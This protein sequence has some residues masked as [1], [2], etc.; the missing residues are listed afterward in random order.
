MAFENIS[1]LVKE[2]EFKVFKDIAATEKGAVIAACLPKGAELS[3]KDIDNLTEYVKAEGGSGLA[4]FRVVEGKLDSPIAKFFPETLQK[5]LIEKL[6]ANA[7]D[8]ILCVADERPKALKLLGLVRLQ[9]G[10]TRGLIDTKQFHFSWVTDFPLFQFDAEENRWVSEHHPF[11]SPNMEDWS[12]HKA[13]GNLGAIRSSAYDL[14][15]NGNEVAS[16]SIRIHRPDLQKEIFDTI[17]L[18]EEEIQ[19]RFGFLLKAFRFG[20]PPHGG[21]A[22]GID[23]IVAII[24]GVDSIREVIAFPKNQKAVDPMTSAPSPVN[25]KQLKELGIKIR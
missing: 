13:S 8:M 9:L 6:K 1:D 22:L 25:E 21:I 3:R 5:K 15:L 2:S 24:M 23:R 16:G 17:G 7:G 11:T 18:G 4:Y 10:K 20:A 14:V 12:K 19:E